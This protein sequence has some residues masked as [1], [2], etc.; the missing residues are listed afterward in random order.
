MI[1]KINSNAQFVVYLTRLSVRAIFT[2]LLKLLPLRR[3]YILTRHNH[4]RLRY[5]CLAV[6]SVICGALTLTSMAPHSN[7][8]YNSKQP[9][10]MA[11]TEK[12]PH[13]NKQNHQGQEVADRTCLLYTSPSP[14]D[15]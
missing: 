2:I 1:N 7:A 9:I 12:A 5:V 13:E 4:I 6:S 3:R 11:E 10:Q 14:R 15:A 8:I